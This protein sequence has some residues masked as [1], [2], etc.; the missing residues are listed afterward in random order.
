MQPNPAGA[1][2]GALLEVITG[3]GPVVKVQLVAASGLPAVA[4]VIPVLRLAVYLVSATSAVTTSPSMVIC[5]RAALCAGGVSPGARIVSNW[6]TDQIHHTN[7]R[8]S[9]ANPRSAAADTIPSI[10][11][12]PSIW[13]VCIFWCARSIR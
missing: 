10:T 8:E 2:A 9:A 1:P 11:R 6:P 5:P 13:P 12:P 3:A 7:R 4:S